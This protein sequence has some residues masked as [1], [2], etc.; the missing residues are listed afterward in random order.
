MILTKTI[1]T[2]KLTSLVIG[3]FWMK[4]NNNLY[5][6]PFS[7][8]QIPGTMRDYKGAKFV[9]RTKNDYY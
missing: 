3:L 8:L 2:T 1:F 4:Q 6:Y 7:Y 5:V 9:A